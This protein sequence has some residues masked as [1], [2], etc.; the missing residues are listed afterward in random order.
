MLGQES[1]QNPGALVEE[2]GSEKALRPSSLSEAGYH[3]HL[4]SRENER[5]IQLKKLLHTWIQF[6]TNTYDGKT[7][8]GQ[9]TKPQSYQS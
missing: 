5:K 1:I 3:R 7:F 6:V 4:E 9:A 2:N 8:R